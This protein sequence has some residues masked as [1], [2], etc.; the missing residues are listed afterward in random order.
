MAA[1]TEIE[2]LSTNDSNSTAAIDLIGNALAN[3]I[4]G[5]AGNNFLNG[6][7]GTDTLEGLGRGRTIPRR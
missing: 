6:G 1:A 4:G 5:N 7:G 3:V 2:T